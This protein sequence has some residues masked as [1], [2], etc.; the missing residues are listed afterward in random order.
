MLNFVSPFPQDSIR[1]QDSISSP[2]TPSSPST[3]Q[4]ASPFP[5]SVIF[6]ARL[7][8]DKGGE[9]VKKSKKQSVNQKSAATK[10]PD[11]VKESI[12]TLE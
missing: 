8:A 11:V 9:R 12:I 3:T 7:S 5:T 6:T 10:G 1:I 4:A 2:A